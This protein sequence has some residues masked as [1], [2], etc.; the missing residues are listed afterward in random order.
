[1]SPSGPKDRS[2]RRRKK[3][4][5]NQSRIVLLASMILVSVVL[6]PG[7]SDDDNP[8]NDSNHSPVIGSLTS[9]E[10]TVDVSDT[11]TLTCTASDQDGDTLTYNWSAGAGS[12]NGTGSSVI[13]T[14]PN[15]SGSVIIGCEVSDVHGA[16]VTDSIT[17][18]VTRQMPTQGLILHYPFSGSAVDASGN[19]NDGTVHGATLTQDRFNNDNSA[20]AF[21]GSDDYIDVGNNV[22]PLLPMSVSVW[23]KVNSLATAGC[24]F[25]NDRYDNT[26]YRYGVSL[27]YS[28]S[29]Q[30]GSYV[31]EG[32]S[33]S[34]NRLGKVSTDSV[35]TLNEWHHF[36]VV[37]DGHND[38]SLFWDSVEL[39]GTYDGTGSGLSYSS[40]NGAIGKTSIAQYAFDG[41]IDDIRVYDRALSVEEIGTL[42]LEG[43]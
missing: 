18:M 1:M 33:A 20:Y 43:Q 25:R 34:W 26:A 21:D 39:T 24:V 15:V 40:S 30:I 38:H 31:F 36:V 32:Y 14:S 11:C 29:G 6:F 13:W 23:V 41:C 9:S 12:I 22:K 10:T 35:V 27:M 37:F 2:K 28:I 3:L 16:A 4:I 19:S 5:K 17:I 42:F 8:V 7:C